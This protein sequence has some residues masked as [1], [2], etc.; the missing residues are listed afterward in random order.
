M[1]ATLEVGYA[2]RDITPQTAVDL[3][4]FAGR[5]SPSTGV[6]DALLAQALVLRQGDTSVL[7]LAA[8][9]L[10][11]PGS[12]V[13][14]LRARISALTGL[15][16]ERILL[17]TSHTHSG[18]ATGVVR[19]M[20][21]PDE[22]YLADVLERMA[23]AA[24]EAAARSEERSVWVAR[25]PVHIAVNRRAMAGGRCT[26]I[27]RN[28]AGPLAP[29]VDVV[30]FRDAAGAWC[31]VIF[32]TATHPVCLGGANLL[33][34]AD[35]PGYA[36]RAIGELPGQPAALFLQGCCGDVNPEAVGRG[37]EAAQSAGAEVGRAVREAL[38]RAR[39]IA[40]EPLAAASERVEAPLADCPDEAA[41]EALLGQE[42]QALAEARERGADRYEGLW[43]EGRVQWAQAMLALARTPR[44][45]RVQ[46]LEV[47]AVRVGELAFVALPGE[48][49]VEYA[50]AIDAASPFAHTIVVGQANASVGYVPT[51]RALAE[52]GYEVAEAPK[53]YGTVT[54]APAVEP[55]LK[56]TAGGLLAR[57]AA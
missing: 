32:S 8:D 34:S 16:D 54:F 22:T 39:L 18:P 10:G 41:A 31:E 6:L 13:E 35:Y 42:Q 25:E 46:A 47:Q 27:G 33:I 20:G 23:E 5:R 24:A 30:A 37:A 48:V 44:E 19:S 52:G 12:F 4:G 1:S 56:A 38:D 53:Y 11:L 45:R 36:R 55:L 51:A 50:I 29:Y 26:G 9:L 2:V 49:F 57:L 40:A 43:H 14:R 21:T 28:P 3:T 7:I 15:T 17:N